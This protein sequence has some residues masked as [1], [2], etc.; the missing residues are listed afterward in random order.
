MDLGEFPYQFQMPLAETTA[1]NLVAFSTSNETTKLKVW[2]FDF[3]NNEISEELTINRFYNGT[4]GSIS[5]TAGDGYAITTQQFKEITRVVKS[6]TNSSVVLYAIEP[7][8]SKMWF[9]A[10][11]HSKDTIPMFRRYRV[12]NKKN[13]SGIDGDERSETC[14][15][16]MVKLG[17]SELSE[18]DDIVLID[19]I[20]ALKMMLIA[21]KYENEGN[22][23]QAIQFES[24]AVRILE[25]VNAHHKVSQG[26]PVIIDFE[27]RLMGGVTNRWPYT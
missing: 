11:Y 5:G 1:Y 6:E 21:I 18:N 13:K 2:G 25:D 12:I 20:S 7:G 24:N 9:V 16:A 3:K 4:E 17:Y 14:I 23:T 26:T 19:S 22:L 10:K 27:R 8:T 15:L